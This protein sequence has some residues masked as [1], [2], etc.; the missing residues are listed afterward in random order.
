LIPRTFKPSRMI[1]PAPRNPTPDTTWAATRVVLGSC[2]SF[3]S[4]TNRAAPA[5]TREFVRRPAMRW[6][7]WHSEPTTAPHATATSSR[8]ATTASGRSATPSTLTSTPSCHGVILSARSIGFDL[9]HH[10]MRSRWRCGRMTSR[11]RTSA[12]APRGP[13]GRKVSVGGHS[14]A[15]QR[16][17]CGSGS[18]A[19]GRV[20]P[21]SR[22]SRPRGC[23]VGG[24]VPEPAPGGEDVP[25]APEG[26][27]L[28]VRLEFVGQVGH[29]KGHAAGSAAAFAGRSRTNSPVL[30]S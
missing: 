21:T 19:S 30:A 5:A 18:P 29:R 11:K 17:G 6:R 16:H 15:G 27:P 10:Q 14:R 4:S 7:H 25:F 9:L 12:S 24:A 2:R 26:R 3:P 20:R 1:T 8:A 23:V 28:S 22:R 13:R